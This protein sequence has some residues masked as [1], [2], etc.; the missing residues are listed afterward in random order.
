MTTLRGQHNT[1]VLRS[2]SAPRREQIWD[3][4]H[5]AGVH[6]PQYF[7]G[8]RIEVT[9]RAALSLGDHRQSSWGEDQ[10]LR[11]G[12]AA[13]ASYTVGSRPTTPRDG[14]RD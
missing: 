13:Q 1:G 5:E 9:R 11:R 3:A 10:V 12:S 8:A 6:E 2:S 7:F 14:C 4:I